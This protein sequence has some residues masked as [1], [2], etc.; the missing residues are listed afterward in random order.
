[1]KIATLRR[2]FGEWPPQS[3]AKF[4]KETAQAF[5]ANADGL[6]AKDLVKKAEDM[7]HVK[8]EL[9]QKY[10]TSGGEFLPLSV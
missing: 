7:F 9:N 3:F 2:G 10:Y 1:M 4:P 6:R 5:F 8:E